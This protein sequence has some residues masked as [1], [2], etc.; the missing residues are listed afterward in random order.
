[1]EGNKWGIP[2]STVVSHFGTSGVSVAAATGI[3]H[4]LGSF[5]SSFPFFLAKLLERKGQMVLFFPFS[6][7]SV[8]SSIF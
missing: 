7:N 5:N 2:L 6:I 8:I 4:P 3:T 1:M